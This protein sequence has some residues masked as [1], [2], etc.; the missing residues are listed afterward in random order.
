MPKQVWRELYHQLGI[1]LYR[2]LHLLFVV[3]HY[4]LPYYISTPREVPGK[5]GVGNP[6]I[7][8]YVRPNRF[9]Y[10]FPLIPFCCGARV[11]FVFTFFLA[12]L[13]ILSF[14]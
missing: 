9:E 13:V 8:G 5:S 3:L 6:I 10:P 7:P 14:Q 11:F 4:M 2:L 1:G 12:I